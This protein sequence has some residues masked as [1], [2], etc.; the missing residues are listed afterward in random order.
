MGGFGGMFGGRGPFGGFGP[1]GFGGGGAGMFGRGRARRGNVRAAILSVLGD[2]P[3]NGYQIMQAIEE[4]SQGAW[5]PSSGSVY[6]TLQLLE[7]EGLVETLDA[8]PS[9]GS[10]RTYRLTAKGKRHV[11]ENREEIDEEWQQAP[12]DALRDRADLFHSL[13]SI[14]GALMQIVAA[15]TPAQIGDAKKLLGELRRNLY[16]ILAEDPPADDD[17]DE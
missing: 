8:R 15:G 14:G 7:D 10:S 12:D 16:K 4:K 1:G 5:R 13:K 6:P 11:D 9:Q 17:D 2:S 3:L